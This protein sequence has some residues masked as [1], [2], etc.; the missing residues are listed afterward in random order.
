[1]K[2][3]TR[4]RLKPDEQQLLDLYR[5]L[6]DQAIK[7]GKDNEE[8]DK[9]NVESY[10]ANS[11]EDLIKEFKIGDEWEM[12]KFTPG[13]WTTP[14]KAKFS[15]EIDGNTCNVTMP[16][17]I[18]NKKST[19][20]FQKKTDIIDYEG[21]KEELK[22]DLKKKQ[23]K[24]SLKKHPNNNTGDLLE[25]SIP[26]V[27]LGKYAWGEETGGKNYSTD[28]AIKRHNEKVEDL[29]SKALRI[30]TPEHILFV[31]GND[32]FNTDRESPFPAT[33][34]GTPQEN[35]SRWQKIF[36]KG[37]KMII[38][39]IDKLKMIAPVTVKVIAGNHD[40]HKSWYL[41]DVLEV[42][43]EK[44]ENVTIDNS[45]NPYK[46][47]KWGNCLIGL[48]HGNRKD[49][50]EDRLVTWINEQAAKYDGIVFKEIH[51]GDI[52]HLKEIS[53]RTGNSK[54][55]YKYTEDIN[56]VIIRYL[57]TIM[58][59]DAWEG[60]K[61]YNSQ[62]GAHAFIWNKTRGNEWVLNSNQ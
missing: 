47:F 9:L 31:V 25:I 5:T 61:R 52:H 54:D 42:K 55:L 56:G 32:L 20:I 22:K 16:I 11:P 14:V 62:K 44:D 1:M 34:A 43:Y 48:S 6:K 33:T 23:R 38:E 39:N 10:L 2:D 46:T 58:Y 12:V 13:G 41:G 7:K 26:D 53:Q 29:I 24:I 51:C 4:P 8:G 19:G 27:H 50:S 57:K 35:D 40:F 60:S 49:A 15:T 18:E 37:R 3:E 28:I 30:S 21:F 45:A 17:I 59:N 36:R